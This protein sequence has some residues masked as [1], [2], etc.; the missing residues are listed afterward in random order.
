MLCCALCLFPRVV[1]WASHPCCDGGGA[2]AL[3]FS[4]GSRAKGLRGG[5]QT[6]KS[7][8]LGRPTGRTEADVSLSHR[9]RET[10]DRVFSHPVFKEPS[11]TSHAY[12][13]ASQGTNDFLTGTVR[14]FSRVAAHDGTACS[15]E[16][17]RSAR[18]W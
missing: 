11:C 1:G 4:N 7:R 17:Q 14:G 16:R 10:Q 3:L 13:V 18:R 9:A 8:A 6:Q 5:R 15:Y 2:A 12:R